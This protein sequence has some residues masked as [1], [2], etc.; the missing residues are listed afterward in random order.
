MKPI[1]QFH[2]TYLLVQA[3]DDL[4]IIDQHAAHERICYEKLK[5]QFQQTQIDIQQLLFP[6]ALE[7]SHR[8]YAVLEEHLELFKQYGLEL[9]PFGGMTYLLKAVP[10]LLAKAD[11]KKLIYDIVDQLTEAGKT[12]T[13]AL[14][15]KERHG[16]HAL[17]ASIGLPHSG[18]D[19]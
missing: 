19:R 1:G 3:G 16:T 9:E 2:E 14:P 12:V 6:V 10:T 5:A 8:E 15:E 13:S 18:I 4:F 11:Y 17:P 7:L